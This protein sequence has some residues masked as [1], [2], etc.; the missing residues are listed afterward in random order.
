MK[1]ADIKT[2]VFFEVPHRFLK[3]LQT[4]EEIAPES[5]LVVCRELTKQF[6]EVKKGT[7][8]G[9]LHYFKNPK[10][11]SVIVLYPH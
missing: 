2:L 9:L 5:E 11:E 1:D 6:E 10:G 7:A 3:T 8:K 4:I